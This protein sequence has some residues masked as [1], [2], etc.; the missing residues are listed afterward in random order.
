MK[1]TVKVILKVRAPIDELTQP[2]IYEWHVRVM[3]DG[4][5]A[6]VF[7]SDEV[8]ADPVKL[9]E[10]LEAREALLYRMGVYNWKLQVKVEDK[11]WEYEQTLKMLKEKLS[12]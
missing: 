4:L 8:G 7:V 3:V 2:D 11:L 1:M 6:D 5:L 9:Q 10:W 12:F